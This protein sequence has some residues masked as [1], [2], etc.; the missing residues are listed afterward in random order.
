[1]SSGARGRGASA[2]AAWT[3]AIPA[4][5]ANARASRER[6]VFFMASPRKATVSYQALPRSAPGWSPSGE[7]RRPRRAGEALRK[8]WRPLRDGAGGL[9]GI[10][11]PGETLR[12][13]LRGGP[14]AVQ[15]PRD[16]VRSPADSV[17]SPRDPVQSPPDAL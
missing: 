6:T 17:E 12:G 10:S 16:P 5:P 2:G 8:P 15:S 1:M 13:A 4:E 9:L 3:M 7:T 11:R 14:G